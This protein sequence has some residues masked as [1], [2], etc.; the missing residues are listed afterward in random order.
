MTK[1]EN[2]PGRQAQREK[3]LQALLDPQKN[4]EVLVWK[5]GSSRHGGNQ[6]FLKYTTAKGRHTGNFQ[7]IVR[8]FENIDYTKRISAIRHGFPAKMIGETA[9]LFEIK[10]GDICKTL[11]LSNAT[12]SRKVEKDDPLPAD[13][14]ERLDRLY[15]ITATATRILGSERNAKEWVRTPNQA[16]GNK[17]PIEMIGT[18]I[19]GDQIKAVL[20]AIEYGG[21]V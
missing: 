11:G 13:V 20:A 19:E 6:F 2:H 15:E 14:S 21:A 9:Y 17:A 18:G 3:P 10:K 5:K 8:S 7:Q 12:L 4:A 1:P 16:L